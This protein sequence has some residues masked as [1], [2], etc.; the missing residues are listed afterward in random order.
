MPLGH[1]SSIFLAV[2]MKKKKKTMYCCE[3]VEDIMRSGI[4]LIFK[5]SLNGTE[6]LILASVKY[7]TDR[8]VQPTAH[9]PHAAMENS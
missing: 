6:E 8:H 7:T 9:R 4:L 2:N 3:E 1:V 5:C